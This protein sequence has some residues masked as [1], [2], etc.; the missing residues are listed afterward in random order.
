MVV[1]TWM[2]Q[3]YMMGRAYATRKSEGCKGETW[4]MGGNKSK[5]QV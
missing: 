4:V 3:V 2:G 1:Q 5:V